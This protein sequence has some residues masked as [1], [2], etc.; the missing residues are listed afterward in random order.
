MRGLG[1]AKDMNSRRY[2]TNNDAFYKSKEWRT[3]RLEALQRD[4]YLCQECKKR[5]IVTPA[6]TV[7]H[8]KPLRVDASR[9]L[10]LSNLEAV[11]GACHN[12]LHRERPQA[13]KKKNANIEARR[14]KNIVIFDSN[15]EQW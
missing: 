13:L 3:L 10:Q 7:H 8:I 12:R 9:A 14:N 2:K 6:D 5:G 1:G 15:P 4:S 11:C